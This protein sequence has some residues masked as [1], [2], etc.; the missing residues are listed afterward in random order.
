MLSGE[1]NA[2]NREKKSN[3]ACAA[4]FF[5][6]NISLPLFFDNYEL[7]LPE[8]SYSVVTRF[9]EEMSY[10]FSFTFFQCRSF[11][12][13]I[14]GCQ[15]FSFSHRRYKSFM[16]FFQQFQLQNTVALFL[17]ELRWPAAY[18]HFPPVFLLLY[19]P[20]FWT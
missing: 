5:C 6:T 7:K 1:G 20:N 16:L 9:M 12:P 14:G 11:S 15:H 18:I 2:E 10:V 17:V 19:I 8:T 4:H 3:F 13:C